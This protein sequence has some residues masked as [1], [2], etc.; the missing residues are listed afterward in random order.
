[1]LL[2]KCA[3]CDRKKSR[4]IKEQKAGGLLPGLNS[5]KCCI[6]DL[7]VALLVAIF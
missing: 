6:N 5:L 4:L 7:N 2:S 1:M 3:V